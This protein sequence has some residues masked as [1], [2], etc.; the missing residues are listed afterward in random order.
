[1]TRETVGYVERLGL[2]AAY[3]EAAIEELEAEICSASVDGLSLRAIAAATG[4]SHEK[5]RQI[6]TRD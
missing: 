4:V 6:L 2:A 3:L 5:V 1:M